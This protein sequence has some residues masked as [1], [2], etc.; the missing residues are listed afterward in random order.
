M[1]K[2][3]TEQFIEKAEQVH[4]NKYDYSKI[5]Y[6]NNRTKVCIIC[7]EHG[8][9]WQTPDN[10]LSGNG[11]PVCSGHKKRNTEEFIKD[12]KKIHSNKYDYSKVAFVDLKTKVCIICPKHGEFWQTPGNHLKGEN[13]PICAGNKENNISFVEKAKAKYGNRFDYSKVDYINSQTKVCIICPKHGEFWQKPI[14]HLSKKGTGC[15]KCNGN[16]RLSLQEFIKRAKQI[17]GNKYNYSKVNYRSLNIKVCII[18]PK[19]G[20]F[21]Q[22][23]GNHLKGTGCSH[24]KKT[25]GEKKIENFLLENKIN[26]IYNQTIEQLKPF[27]PDFYL[28]DYNLVIEYD[29]EQHFKP[30]KFFNG[31]E[32]FKK[33]KQR[34]KEKEELCRLN[35]IDII[36]IPFWNTKNIE[37]ILK[38]KLEIL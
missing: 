15:P 35:N 31:E 10:H 32:G 5:N 27:R 28:P 19:H 16:A 38:T 25:K 3:T 4:G 30:I 2:L 26:Y 36:R 6:V 9:F 34:D 37:K 21:W 23:P 1:K 33:R 12:A 17:H 8:E 22:K 24:C 13:C 18:C 20:E 11:C 29:G 14:I 7:S